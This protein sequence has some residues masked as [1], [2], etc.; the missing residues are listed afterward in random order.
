MAIIE[1]FADEEL[2][3]CCQIDPTRTQQHANLMDKLGYRISTFTNGVCI[4][5][6]ELAHPSSQQHCF[7]RNLNESMAQHFLINIKALK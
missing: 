4:T 5:S 3:F 1:R 7:A 6:L 2:R